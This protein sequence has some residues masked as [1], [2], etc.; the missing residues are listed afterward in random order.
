MRSIYLLVILLT[1][2]F[3]P[4]FASDSITD[5]WFVQFTVSD[6]SLVLSDV[7][8][9]FEQAVT[10]SLVVRAPLNYPN[11]FNLRTGTTIG[12]RLNTDADIEIKFFDMFGVNI[13]TLRINKG[14]EGGRKYYNR[15]TI[16]HT[17]FGGYPLSTGPYFYLIISNGKILGKGRMMLK[18][19]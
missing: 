5:F 7:S 18:Q 12:Y 14:Q 15:V 16:D 13:K 4:V 10:P 11:P 2:G 19:P 9:S 1:L 17:T 3:H 6:Q 8:I